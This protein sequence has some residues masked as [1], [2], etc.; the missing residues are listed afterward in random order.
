MKT[1]STWKE[2][3]KEALKDPSFKKAYN[4]LEPEFKLAGSLI[5]ARID[6]KLTQQQLAEKAGVSQT[7]VARLE[8]GETNPTIGTINRVASILGKE[9]RL[10]GASR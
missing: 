5:Q 1:V 6:N 3:K 7:V 2:Y 8:S 10:V 9:L 4:A